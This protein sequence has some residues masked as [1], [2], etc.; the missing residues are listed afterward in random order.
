VSVWDIPGQSRAAGLL[1]SAVEREEVS[2]AWAF[3]GPPGVGQERAARVLAAALSC[4]VPEPPCGRCATCDRILRGAHPDY[5]ELAPVGPAHRVSDVRERWLPVASRTSAEGGWKVLRVIDADR[6]NETAANAFLKGLEEPPPRTVWILD[7]VDPDELPDTI[8]SRCREV[9]FLPWDAEELDAE[10]SRLGLADPADRGLA[11]RACLGSPHA[12]RR[13]AADG[14][15]D[16]LRRHR[17]IPGRLRDDG[18]GYALVAAGELGGEVKRTE[19]ALGEQARLER[20]GLETSYG[21]EIPKAVERE[22]EERLKR[23][24]REARTAVVQ[25]ALDDLVGWYRDCVL[26][27]AGGDPGA[28]IHADASAALAADAESLGTPAILEAV[29][30]CLAAREDLEMNVNVPLRL[31]ALFLE[32]S[33]LTRR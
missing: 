24:E 27:S 30:L 4:A 26:V 32:L 18:P 25:A 11:I 6:M 8:L 21:G 22:L 33:A 29:D 13:L 10:A 20:Q 2:H 14:G 1:R 9:R 7:V 23:R 28:A 19:K 3:V 5:W 15:L 17:A 31:E 12:L 16:D